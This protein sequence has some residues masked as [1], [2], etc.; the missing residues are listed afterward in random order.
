MDRSINKPMFKYMFTMTADVDAKPLGEAPGGFRMDLAY[1]NG[2]AETRASDYCS[3]WLTGVDVGDLFP[4]NGKTSD[5]EAYEILRQTRQ[6]GGAGAHPLQALQ[7]RQKLEWFGFEG[8]FLRGG[9][10]AIVRSDGVGQFSGRITLRSD[11]PDQAVVDANLSGVVDLR[12]RRVD[13]ARPD[14]TRAADGADPGRPRR[15]YRHTNAIGDGS[16]LYNA[17]RNGSLEAAGP[18]ET[19]SDIPLCL[20]ISFES[21]VGRAESWAT[22]KLKRQT[23][24]AW[25]VLRLLRGQ[26]VALGTARFARTR[27]SRIEHIELHI[28]EVMPVRNDRVAEVVPGLRHERPRGT[29]AVIPHLPSHPTQPT[30]PILA[31]T[32]A[33]DAT[34]A[35]GGTW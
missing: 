16:M 4:K 14:E 31:A 32:A 15:T 30:H 22:D 29:E 5:Q 9:D 27:Y 12:L 23:A 10:W 7:S 33:A 11:D 20:A 2:R 17:W 35:G 24:G 1:S 6:S 26:F 28:C 34:L 18:G 25:K 19:F 21:A 13:E 8:S 3:D